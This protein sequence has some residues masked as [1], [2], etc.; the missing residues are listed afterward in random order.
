[1]K[2]DSVLNQG[3]LKEYGTHS[4]E[5]KFDYGNLPTK[6]LSINPTTIRSSVARQFDD[7]SGT[8]IEVGDVPWPS[9]PELVP[10]PGGQPRWPGLHPQ[11]PELKRLLCAKAPKDRWAPT[12]VIFSRG[13]IVVKAINIIDPNCT[14][15]SLKNQTFG[16]MIIPYYPT[17]SHITHGP[18]T[19]PLWFFPT[20]P[21]TA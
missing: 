15:R 13:Q 11:G 1:M 10:R 9:W 19:L 6:T 8:S 18:I 2:I 21:G 7:V 12:W 20:G 4:G 17:L 5:G 14:Q 16:K 3:F